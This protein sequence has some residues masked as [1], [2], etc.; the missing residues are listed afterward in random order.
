MVQRSS[1][2]SAIKQQAHS[3]N[4]RKYA[5]A[6]KPYPSRAF[7][8]ESSKA[9]GR[10]KREG[11]IYI[12]QGNTE[13]RRLNEKKAAQQSKNLSKEQKQG[14]PAQLRLINQGEERSTS[15]VTKYDLLPPYN[16]S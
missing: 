12:G 8:H 9:G 13:A 16:I 3:T 2:P 5:H 1:L 14:L 11:R 7:A 15:L 4:A 6:Q 10:G